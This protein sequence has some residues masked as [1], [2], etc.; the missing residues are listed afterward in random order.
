MKNV[1]SHGRE[2]K[3]FLH[4]SAYASSEPTLSHP[5]FLHFYSSVLMYSLYYSKFA[6]TDYIGILTKNSYL[7]YQL[8]CMR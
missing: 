4:V 8:L 7:K 3:N 6:F 5:N 2:K 1:P